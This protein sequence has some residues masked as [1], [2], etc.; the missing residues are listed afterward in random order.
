[1]PRTRVKNKVLAKQYI[2]EDM[3]M[4][5]VVRENKPHIKPGSVR[6]AA[7]RILNNKEFKKTLIEE[8]ELKGLNDEKVAEIHRRN[9]TQE[10]NLTAS[11][12][13]IDM[14]N[15]VK[16]NYAPQRSENITLNLTGKELQEHKKNLLEEL[17]EV[18]NA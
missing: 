3:N 11:N 5:A 8:L 17:K 15:K 16:G 1:M 13:A 14:Y 2:A 4:S 6:V 7:S 18:S 9:L 12:T 10:D